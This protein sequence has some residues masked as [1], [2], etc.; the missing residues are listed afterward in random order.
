MGPTV[1]LIHPWMC[2]VS[3]QVYAVHMLMPDCLFIGSSFLKQ[4]TTLTWKRQRMTNFQRRRRKER[5]G[6]RR[7]H[8][9][10]HRLRRRLKERRKPDRWRRR[11][12]WLGQRTLSMIPLSRR[13]RSRWAH[14][15]TSGREWQT[16]ATSNSATTAVRCAVTCDLQPGPCMKSWELPMYYQFTPEDL[17]L[18]MFGDMVA[19]CAPCPTV[20]S[21]WVRCAIQSTTVLSQCRLQHLQWHKLFVRLCLRAVMYVCT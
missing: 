17:A 18:Y 10:H 5:G 12:S 9:R 1:R 7:L 6:R 20:S 15:P 11:S 19:I 3:V 21:K 8:K 2:C 13:R 16:H 14:I 4:L